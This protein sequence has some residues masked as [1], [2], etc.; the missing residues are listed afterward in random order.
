[1]VEWS[2]N[3]GSHHNPAPTGPEEDLQ[4]PLFPPSVQRKCDQAQKRGFGAEGCDQHKVH[5]HRGT[6]YRT[7]TGGGGKGQYAQAQLVCRHYQNYCNARN[8]CSCRKNN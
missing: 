1:M 8:A 5:T 3:L 2:I 4:T 6:G 7:D